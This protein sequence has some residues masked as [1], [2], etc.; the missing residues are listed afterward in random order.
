MK[1]PWFIDSVSPLWDKSTGKGV[2]VYVLDSGFPMHQD[3]I[4]VTDNKFNT[5]ND[6]NGHATHISGII[7]QIAPDAII[8]AIKVTD[9]PPDLNMIYDGLKSILN[10]VSSKEKA[11]VNMSLSFSGDNYEIHNL[12]EKL[13]SKNI[14]VVCASGNRNG[15]ASWYPAAYEESISVAS[16]TEFNKI[17][18]FTADDPTIDIFAPG[19]NINSTWLCNQYHLMS[20]TSQAAAYISGILAIILSVQPGRVG[21]E[22]L[23]RFLRENGTEILK[24]AIRVDPSKIL[25]NI[26]IPIESKKLPWYNAFIKLFKKGVSY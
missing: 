10:S 12:I 8:R 16:H 26:E 3:L 13:N 25:Q 20:G 24:G 6:S 18:I 2:T 7:H 19:D 17:S 11:I 14:P 15:G 22:A 4:N 21:S 1:S 23:V 5:P 9:G